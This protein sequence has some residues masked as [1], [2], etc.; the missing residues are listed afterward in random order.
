MGILR[1]A[2][3]SILDVTAGALY[4]DDDVHNSLMD[5]SGEMCKMSL[6]AMKV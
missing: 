2:P 1:L 4:D 3:L 6:E 5:D